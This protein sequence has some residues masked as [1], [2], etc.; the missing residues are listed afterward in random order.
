[1]YYWPIL[2]SSYWIHWTKLLERLQKH[3]LKTKIDLTLLAPEIVN[4][5]KNFCKDKCYPAQKSSYLLES[6]GE[7][8][9]KQRNDVRDLQDVA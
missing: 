2:L 4:W 1:M 5:T 6:S 7:Q 9:L 3:Y 8:V